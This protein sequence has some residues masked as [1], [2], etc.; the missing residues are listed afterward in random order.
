M[1]KPDHTKLAVVFVLSLVGCAEP[2]AE[3]GATKS[4]PLKETVL[5]TYYVTPGKEKELQE[6]LARV[7]DAYEKDHLVLSQPHVV[8][9]A[10]EGEDKSRFVEI[11]SWVSPDAPDHAPDSVKQLWDHMQACCEK[12]DDHQGLEGGEVEL[13]MPGWL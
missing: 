13:L 10:K 11:F 5:I 4:P 8:V 7:W 6:L 1:T 3:R 2:L 12:R 9:R